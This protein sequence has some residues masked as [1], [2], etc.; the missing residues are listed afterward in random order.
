[1][2]WRAA[3]ARH[4]CTTYRNKAPC[5]TDQRCAWVSPHPR[6]TR[7]KHKLLNIFTRDVKDSGGR[8][9]SRR[10]SHNS[11]QRHASASESSSETDLSSEPESV[12]LGPPSSLATSDDQGGHLSPAHPRGRFLSS[13]AHSRPRGQETLSAPRHEEGRRDDRESG[14]PPSSRTIADHEPAGGL[15]QHVTPDASDAHAPEMPVHHGL[16]VATSQ[17]S[18]NLAKIG[19]AA[20]AKRAPPS[21]PPAEEIE[22]SDSEASEHAVRER[23]EFHN[24]SMA[25]RRRR[26]DEALKQSMGRSQERHGRPIERQ[27]RFKPP[28]TSFGPR[29]PTAQ[30]EAILRSDSRVSAET[31][32]SNAEAARRTVADMKKMWGDKIRTAPPRRPGGLA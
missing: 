1:M 18:G 31:Q 8:C 9:E 24:L 10:D 13:S 21:P 20:V 2:S 7:F 15:R 30:E 27:Y 22:E 25:E 28:D 5:E 6:G 32:A 17:A 26:A 11:L 12:I 16:D 3:V 23:E 14:A 19:R 29:K 4:T